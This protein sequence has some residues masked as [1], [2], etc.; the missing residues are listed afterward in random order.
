MTMNAKRILVTGATGQQ[1]GAVARHL[2]KQ[3]GFQVRA[4]VRDTAKPSSR[5]L[6]GQGAELIQGDLNDAASIQ[7]ALQGMHGVFSVQTFM[8][9]GQDGEIRQGKALADAAK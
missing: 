1:G 3:G 2:L 4:L 6:A 9:A 7:R 5:A 8:E